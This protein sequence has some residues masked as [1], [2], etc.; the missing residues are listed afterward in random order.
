MS[1]SRVAQLAD[2]VASLSLEEKYELMALVADLL[3][4]DEEFILSRRRE[5]LE[6]KTAGRT[7]DAFEA[8]KNAK[9]RRKK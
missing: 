4:L 5:A 3:K 2:Q 6:D 7:I 1:K 9:A 8:V